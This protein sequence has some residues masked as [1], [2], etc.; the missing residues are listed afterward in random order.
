MNR[1][2]RARFDRLV[3]QA[4]DRLPERFRAALDIIPVI[5][6]DTPEPDLVEQ[7]LAE[8]VLGHPDEALEL[9]GLHTGTALT[10]RSIEVPQHPDQ[11]HLFRRGIVELAG[12]WNGPDALESIAREIQTTLLHELGHHFGL[13]ED[14]LDRLGYA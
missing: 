8:G 11:I 13:D 2:D 1:A 5:V 10:E 12:G 6:T 7:L 14:D 4:M 3:E 9:C